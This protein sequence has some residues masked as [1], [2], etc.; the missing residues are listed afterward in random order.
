MKIDH[1]GIAV[2]DIESAMAT[3]AGALGLRPGPVEEVAGQGIRAHHLAVGESQIELLE[4]LDEGSAVARFL[5]RRG[6]GIHHI[7]FAVEDFDG[8][9]ARLIASGSRPL[10]EPS[11]GA[12]GKRIQFFDPRST[13]GVLIEICAK[14]TA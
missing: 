7:A 12:G 4:S 6:P 11:V 5:A 13:G 8:A 10:G 2:A 1:I 9:R 14:G 3:Y